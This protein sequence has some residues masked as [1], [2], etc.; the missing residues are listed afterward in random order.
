MKVV[1]FCGGFGTRISDYSEAVPKPMVP[2]GQ[3]PIMLHIMK[4]YSQ[5]GHHD[6]I[7]CL[8]Y[9]ANVIKDFILNYKPETHSDCVVNN[10]GESITQLGDPHPKW[11]VSMIDTGM[12]RNIG[13]R[14]WAVRDFLKDEEYFLANY[15][16]GVTDAPLPQMIDNL[17]KS[18]KVASF[19]ATRNPNRF[20]LVDFDE[21]DNV[22][23]FRDSMDSNIWINAGYFVLTPKIFDYMGEGEELVIE[24]FARLIEEDQLIAYKHDGFFRAMDTLKEK[25]ELEFMME[26]G[27]IP[28]L[29]HMDNDRRQ[30][31]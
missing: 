13:E 14:L 22:R 15:S 5:Y 27:E 25:Q 23:S 20:H 26:R 10:F 11:N 4:Y 18:G 12:W 8:G 3:Q 21:N 29:A 30:K 6:F 7:L 28:W 9:K 19:M 16:D 2:V 31:K 1:L 24:P 17:K